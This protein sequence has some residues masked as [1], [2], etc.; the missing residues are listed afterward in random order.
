MQVIRYE[1]NMPPIGQ[2]SVVALGFFDGV[3]LAHRRLIDRAR[4]IA[5]QDGLTLAVFTFVSETDG[6]KESAGRL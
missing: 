6:Y 4:A 1:P 3:H 5:R 2:S